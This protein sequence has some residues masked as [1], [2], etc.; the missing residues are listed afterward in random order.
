MAKNI[1]VAL[2]LDTSNFNR[3]LATA[4]GKVQGLGSSL[5][6]LKTAIAGL[7]TGFA[8]KG[9]L[10]ATLKM[11]GFKTTLTAYLGTQEQA[12]QAIERLSGLAKGLPQDVDDIT[13]SFIILQRNGIDTANESMT[14]FSKVAAGNSKTFGQLAEAVADA[15]TGEFERLKEFGVKVSK[16]NDQFAIRFADG[17]QKVVD[18]AAEVVEAVKAQG[19]EGGKFA[20]VVAGPL[21]QAISNLRGIVFEVSSAF[22]EGFAPALAE[23]ASNIS[24]ALEANKEFIAS[25][26]T[27]VGEGIT[28]LIENLDIVIPLIAGFGAAWTAVKLVNIA[29]GIM[30]AVTAMRALTVAIAANPIGLLITAVSAAI[31]MFVAFAQQVGSA[32][33]A[34]YKLAAGAVEGANMIINAFRGAGEFI[35]TL[36]SELVKNVDLKDIFT[37]D[38]EAL[39]NAASEAAT[40]A[41][42][43]FSAT[44]AEEGPIPIPFQTSIEAFEQTKAMMADYHEAAQ[45]LEEKLREGSVA[46]QEEINALGEQYALLGETLIADGEINA[47]LHQ[48]QMERFKELFEKMFTQKTATQEQTQAT[49]EQQEAEAAKSEQ[50]HENQ[51]ITIE[52]QTTINELKDAETEK[53]VLQQETEGEASIQEH[54]NQETTIGLFGTILEKL[55][56]KRQKTKENQGQTEEEQKSFV[57]GWTSGWN[58]YTNMSQGAI[59]AKKLLWGETTEAMGMAFAAFVQGGKDGFKDLIKSMLKEIMAFLAKAAV[60]KFFG[61]LGGLIGGPIGGLFSLFSGFLDE[62]GRIPAGRFGIVGEKG[63]E[64][65]RGPAVVTG[66]E[67]TADLFANAGRGSTMVTYNINAVDARSFKQLVAQDPEFIYNVTVAGRRRLPV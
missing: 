51:D 2:E 18:S 24:A 29:Q 35:T 60:K 22:G 5:G 41:M 12:N 55:G 20:N 49:T 52:K 57:D 54:N 10:D 4:Q 32:E 42:A 26:G 16:E 50:E 36:F 45:Q 39:T 8:V 28:A 44:V 25:L 33:I 17:S 46:T 27:L 3:G 19:E 14:A 61:F 37:G 64:L 58:E 38:T 40:T 63:P 31:A 53:T 9:I 48:Q 23:T 62:G 21:S 56:I 13:E 7:A 47:E 11:E 1:T 6:G 30:G 43:A 65:V 67:D 59:L 66:R 34:F 15:L